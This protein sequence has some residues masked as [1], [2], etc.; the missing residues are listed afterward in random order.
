MPIPELEKVKYPGILIP[1]NKNNSKLRDTLKSLRAEREINFL[2]IH[3]L[4]EELEVANT[5]IAS[6]NDDFPPVFTKEITEWDKVSVQI[7]KINGK[8]KGKK[9]N[10]I[11]SWYFNWILDQAWVKEETKKDIVRFLELRKYYQYQK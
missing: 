4:E 9:W 11:P 10:W 2:R 1:S 6:F 8:F 7:W 5:K 3:A